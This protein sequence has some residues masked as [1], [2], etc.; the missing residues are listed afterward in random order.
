MTCD[1]FG[2]RSGRDRDMIGTR[3]GD[4]QDVTKPIWWSNRDGD[5]GET[6]NEEEEEEEEEDKKEQGTTH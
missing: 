3:S 1:A 6:E 2:T 5:A 4:A